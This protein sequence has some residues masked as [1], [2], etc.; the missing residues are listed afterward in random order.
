[1]DNDSGADGTDE[2]RQLCSPMLTIQ[3]KN[4]KRSEVLCCLHYRQRTRC[5]STMSSN[6]LALD[7]E[8]VQDVKLHHPLSSVA[9]SNQ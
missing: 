4:A 7:L 9:T 1:M 6:V 3:E 2:L 5:A 8:G